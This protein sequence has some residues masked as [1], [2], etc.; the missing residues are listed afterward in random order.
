MIPR[1]IVFGYSLIINDA[2]ALGEVTSNDESLF[3][4][5]DGWNVRS[6]Q[7]FRSEIRSFFEFAHMSM[8]VSMGRGTVPQLRLFIGAF[9][10]TGV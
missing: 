3:G 2:I 4:G 10:L 1:A 7:S 9:V 8:V 6:S 5:V